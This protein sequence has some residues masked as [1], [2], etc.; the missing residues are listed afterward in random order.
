MTTD[1]FNL[2]RFLT[3]QDEVYDDVLAELTAGHK[4]SHWM[5]FVFPQVAGLG[6]SLNAEYFAI[7]SRSEAVAYLEHPILGARLREC[8]G[9][10]LA[11]DGKSATQL[12][13]SP[14]DLKL[15]SSMTLFAQVA[16]RDNIFTR[17]L[18]KYYS[19]VPD[20]ATLTALA[21]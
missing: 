10:L 6:F 18:E 9:L 7:G 4:E 8:A 14:D 12:L 19:G 17:V 11:V 21:V 3:A 5:W 1:P 2:Q 13:G 16:E 15:C 20:P